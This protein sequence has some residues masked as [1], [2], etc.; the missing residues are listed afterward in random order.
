MAVE[1]HGI[2]HV[3]LMVADHGRSVSFYK[4]VF[5]M[6]IGFRDGN[7]LFLHSPNARD[8]LA[9]HLAVTD[10]ERARVGSQGGYEHFGITV[11][12]R[13]QLDDCIALVIAAGGALVDKGE[14]APGFPTPTSLTQ[15]GTSS[16]S[17][18][19]QPPLHPRGIA[20]RRRSRVDRRLACKP[21]PTQPGDA[22]GYRVLPGYPLL[23]DA[24]RLCR[25]RS[26]PRPVLALWGCHSCLAD[27][28]SNAGC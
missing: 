21:N 7:I 4:D 12:D 20:R 27:P 25:L 3:H 24:L 6:E 13:G 26:R 1:T 9:L 19:A 15:T 10:D 11:M 16:K 18:D 28:G 5:G 14:H 23:P 17:N 2:R 8:D 22:G